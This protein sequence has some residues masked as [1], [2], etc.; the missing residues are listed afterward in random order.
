MEKAVR[1]A[2]GK[3]G[4]TT[5]WR[6]DQAVWAEFMTVGSSEQFS[7]KQETNRITQKVRIRYRDDMNSTEYRIN[8]K[9]RIMNIDSLYDPDESRRFIHMRLAE[10]KA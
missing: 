5:E 4:F 3:G 10:V 1:T 6:E 2:N 7:N 9:D 8:F